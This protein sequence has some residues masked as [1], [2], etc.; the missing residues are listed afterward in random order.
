M[1][2]LTLLQTLVVYAET[3][4]TSSA[5]PPWSSIRAE[6]IQDGKIIFNAPEGT[7]APAPLQ[8]T[9]HSGEVL[10]Q[11]TVGSPERPPYLVVSGLPCAGCELQRGVYVIRADGSALEQFVYPGKVKDKKT[12]QLLLQSD[13]YFG[14]CIPGRGE[15]L[16]TFQ[17]EK[18][19]RRRHKQ[20]SVLLVELKDGGIEEKL[21]VKR[22]PSERTAHQ[23]VKKKLCQKIPGIDRASAD[24]LI[25][26]DGNRKE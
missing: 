17:S 8:T 26:P 19:D 25:T 20:S 22:M 18:V 6:R 4:P 21:I 13:S 14:K 10:G 24:E 15:V 11:L 5:P 12:G 9:L 2:L 23:L 3:T 7:P 16:V 1:L